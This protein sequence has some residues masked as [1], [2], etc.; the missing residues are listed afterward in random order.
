M[1]WYDDAWSHR[2]AVTVALDKTLAR[3][4]LSGADA[5]FFNYVQDGGA[6]IRVT[7][8]DGTTEVARDVRSCST[9]GQTGWVV[10]ST[11]VS[12]SATTATYYLYVGNSGASD[13][14]EDA[15]YGSENVYDSEY[16][17]VFSMDED[18]SG[19]APQMIDRTANDNDGTSTGTM[20]SG[21]SVTG[22]IDS[23]VDFDGTDDYITVA[24]S[25]SL[26]MD[27]GVSVG[28]VFEE[29][30]SSAGWTSLVSKRNSSTAN[31]GINFNPDGGTNLFQIYFSS[32]GIQTHTVSWSSNFSASTPY[33]ITATF[34]ESGSDVVTK[35]YK[36]GSL[37]DSKTHTTK[38]LTGSTE[39]VYVGATQTTF[40]GDEPFAGKIDEVFV[41]NTDIAL[42]E[43]TAISDE[44][45][46]NSSVVTFGT[47]TAI[48]SGDSSGLRMGVSL[49][50]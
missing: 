29:S 50:M 18:P 4:D 14:A 39:P 26:K 33:F 24:D 17:L 22:T 38:S 37:L 49:G 8:S 34:A 42:A 11:G 16:A 30:G 9:S 48:A 46:D 47:T 2:I 27:T 28:L 41:M 43:V 1:A 19:T 44:I 20:T 23:A 6:D 40:V 31:Y 7:K 36:N 10:F 25:A 32:A 21:D 3:V 5:T 35:I 12:K 13:Y 15:T 45:M